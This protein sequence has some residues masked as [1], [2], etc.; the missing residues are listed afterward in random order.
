MPAQQKPSLIAT[1]AGTDANAYVTLAFAD[2]FFGDGLEGTD[3]FG[4]DDSNRTRALISATCRDDDSLDVQLKA[5]GAWYGKYDVNDPEQTL[6]FPRSDD[7][8]DSGDLE[9]PDDVE[10]ATCRLA[11]WMLRRRRGDFGPVDVGAM[12]AQGLV[13]VSTGTVN[14]SA[15]TTPW[16]NWPQAVKLLMSKYIERGA[17]TIPGESVDWARQ[18]RWWAGD[19]PTRAG[20]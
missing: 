12:H 6:M 14:V 20:W 19:I 8:D 13:A 1:V 11:L 7:R 10:E 4:F 17:R 15:Y 18:R 9:I 16:N 3:W 2:A 5:S